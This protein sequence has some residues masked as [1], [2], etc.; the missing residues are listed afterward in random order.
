[1]C[2]RYTVFTE[3]EIIEMR[4]IIAEISGHFGSD[5]VRTGEVRPTNHAP[6]LIWEGGRM[7]PLPVRWGFPKWD[8]KGVVINARAESAKQK[9]MF[10]EP[11]RKKRCVIPSTGFFE[12]A[13]VD[14][15]QKKDKYLI[16]EPGKGMLYMA[17]IVDTFKGKSGRHE[18]AFTILTTAANSSVSQLHDRMPVILQSDE[19]EAW[20]R[21]G[22]FVDTVLER[23]GPAL[24]LT[25]ANPM[26]SFE[27][28][29]LF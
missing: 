26:E 12:W 10:K 24:T 28:T 3:D 16:T 23:V 7:T 1:M 6:I 13:H 29:S 25:L 11:L 4:A 15:K 5:F 19:L 9:P 22:A 14:G 2:A 8:G 17:G 21:D 18:D 20:L 27:Q